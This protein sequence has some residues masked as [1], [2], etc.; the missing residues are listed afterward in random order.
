MREESRNQEEKQQQ[1]RR[2]SSF[3]RFSFFASVRNARTHW[4]VLRNLLIKRSG[5]LSDVTPIYVALCRQNVG[6]QARTRVRCRRRTSFLLLFWVLLWVSLSLLHGKNTSGFGRPKTR[7]KSCRSICSY[8][9][10]DVSE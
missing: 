7:N 2:D 5:P 4:C 3:V 1:R 6:R 8:M 10:Q 9:N